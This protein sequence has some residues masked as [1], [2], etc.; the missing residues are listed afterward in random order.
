MTKPLFKR[1]ALIGVGMIGGSFVQA[2]KAAGM[3]EQVIGVDLDAEAINK[4]LALGVIDSGSSIAELSDID[5]IVIATPV[6][7]MG[8]VF[9]ELK[10]AGLEQ[11]LMTDVGS[12]KQSV[13]EAAEQVFGFMP[14]KFVPGH[15]VAGKE[16][17]GVEHA[18]ADLFQNHKA[19]VTPTD[20]T[21]KNAL[22]TVVSM[23]EACGST[24]NIMSAK[25]HDRILAATSH[26]PHVLAYVLVDS[27]AATKDEEC[28][29]TYA[30]GGFKSFTRTASSSP[31][32]WRDVCVANQKAI[33]TWLERYQDK[34]ET[35]KHLIENKDLDAIEEV[36][37]NAKENRDEH[38]EAS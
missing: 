30:A 33:L 24:V 14:E 4:A 36:F 8:L 25:E 9:A 23:W 3:I 12:T 17:I 10:A 16:Y 6:G 38:F 15:P 11:V 32:M 19:I 28:V 29:F 22:A 7:A 37:R 21:D 27:L 18:S 5:A 35:M 26:L 34:L 31:I 2:L 1:L 13:I 20:N